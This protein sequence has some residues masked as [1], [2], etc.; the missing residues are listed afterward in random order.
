MLT[1]EP[2]TLSLILSCLVANSLVGCASDAETG[3][4]GGS[5]Q[6][7]TVE[8]GGAGSSAQD[9]AVGSAGCGHLPECDK[10][11]EMGCSSAGDCYTV[12]GECGNTECTLREGLHC[13]DPLVCNPGDVR[14]TGDQCDALCYSTKVCGKSTYCLVVDGGSEEAPYAD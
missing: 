14:T 4:A 7:G 11:D 13:T 8:A 2:V 9:G 6:D 10:G 1:R 12:H 5:A 3:G